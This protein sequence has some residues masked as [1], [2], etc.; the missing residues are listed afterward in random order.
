MLGFTG[1]LR[2]SVPAAVAE[3]HS[4]GIKVVMITGDY[5]VTAC[6]IGRQAGLNAGQ[7]T[8]DRAERALTGDELER[9]SDDELGKRVKTTVIYARIRPTQELRIVQSLKANGEIVAM[10]GDYEARKIKDVFAQAQQGLQPDPLAIAQL[11]Q[12][13]TLA[14]QS[15]IDD[16]HRGHIDPRQFHFNFTP[17]RPAGLSLMQR[18]TCAKQSSK[19]ACQRRSSSSSLVFRFIHSCAMRCKSIAG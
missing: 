5:P 16:L 3:C 12:K 19:N 10:T 17:P 18:P 7:S 11:E 14:M 1:P 2:A 9:L 13:L 8:D 6:A 15:Y 4:A